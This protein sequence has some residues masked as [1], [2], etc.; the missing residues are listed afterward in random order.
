MGRPRKNMSTKELVEHAEEEVLRTKE[1]YDKAVSKL[2]E[3][4]EKQDKEKQKEML[5]AI[6]KSK[7]SYEQIME[8]VQ[9]DPADFGE[10]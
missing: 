3:A 8:F 10:E 9:R 4:R 1:A 2:K 7:W 6:A 5:N